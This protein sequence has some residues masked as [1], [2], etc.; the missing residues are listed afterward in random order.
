MEFG[1]G[2][3]TCGITNEHTWNFVTQWCGDGAVITGSSAQVKVKKIL[4]KF[5]Q[6]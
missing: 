6:K 5:Q 4:T 1:I 3:P 2:P